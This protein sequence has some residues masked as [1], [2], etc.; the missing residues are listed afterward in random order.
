MYA[1][2]IRCLGFLVRCATISRQLGQGRLWSG[3]SPLFMIN[4]RS[5]YCY[6]HSLY[7]RTCTCDVHLYKYVRMYLHA[8]Y[9]ADLSEELIKAR[10]LLEVVLHQSS[11]H[12][13]DQQLQTSA[14]SIHVGDACVLYVPH[15]GSTSQ[16]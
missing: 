11:Q 12:G 16:I 5:S 3:G 7:V 9:D 6:I 10:H 1:Y 13:S 4:H 8:H 14:C 15:M 2:A